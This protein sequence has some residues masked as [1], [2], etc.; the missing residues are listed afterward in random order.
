MAPQRVVGLLKSV[1]TNHPSIAKEPASQAYIVNFASGAVSFQLR[2]WTDRYEDWVQ[3][4]SDLSF[5]VDEALTERISRLYDATDSG[6]NR[7]LAI[8]ISVVQPGCGLHFITQDIGSGIRLGSALPHA[9]YFAS[10]AVFSGVTSIFIV[11]PG[12]CADCNPLTSGKSRRK[13]FR[14]VSS[15]VSAFSIFS[16]CTPSGV[17]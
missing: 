17:R 8:R 5:A 10:A 6:R 12:G 13:P 9:A 16:I 2:A 4:R 7:A 14:V 1:A 3:V 11:S 15:P